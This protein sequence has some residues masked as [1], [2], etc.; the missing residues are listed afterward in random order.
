MTLQIIPFGNTSQSDKKESSQ[1]GDSKSSLVGNK[2][3]TANEFIRDEAIEKDANGTGPIEAREERD[4]VVKS[5]DQS[6]K[7]PKQ[8]AKESL[9]NEV[10]EKME[11]VSFKFLFRIKELETENLELLKKVKEQEA[12]IKSLTKQNEIYADSN[13]KL[14]NLSGGLGK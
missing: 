1:S 6:V 2:D 10:G 4:Q 11:D 8:P 13:K 5:R 12:I 3:P 9:T 14:S 7:S